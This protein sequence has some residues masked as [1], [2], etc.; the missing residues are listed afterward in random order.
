MVTYMMKTKFHLMGNEDDAS[1]I[2]SVVDGD[3][4]FSK[5][6]TI[7]F[8]EDYDVYEERF[9]FGSY[10]FAVGK[11]VSKFGI[12]DADITMEFVRDFECD[13]TAEDRQ[14]ACMLENIPIMYSPVKLDEPND[15]LMRLSRQLYDKYLVYYRSKD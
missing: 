6:I 8:E 9:W 14:R 2:Y 3:Y 13:I 1:Y 7:N 12:K 5:K 10:Y 11:N 15:V 4:R